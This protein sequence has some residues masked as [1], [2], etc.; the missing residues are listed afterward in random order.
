[1]VSAPLLFGGCWGSGM[2]VAQMWADSAEGEGR[3]VPQSVGCL[4]GA[5]AL[6]RKTGL[7]WGREGL[8]ESNRKLLVPME[9]S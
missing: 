4:P 7:G 8:H 5:L 1:M 6:S 9:W 2:E 3:G